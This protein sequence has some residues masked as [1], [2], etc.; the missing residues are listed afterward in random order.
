MAPPPSVDAD[1]IPEAE[2]QRR[3]RPNLIAALKRANGKVSGEGGAAELLGIN[4][5]TLASRL[6]AHGIRRE[7]VRS[8]L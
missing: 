1:V 6:K 3:E 5:A 7:D 8:H 2:W 4:P